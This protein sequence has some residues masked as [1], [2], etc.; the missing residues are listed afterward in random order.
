MKNRYLISTLALASLTSFAH[1]ADRL[2]INVVTSSE[3]SFGVN[4][5][6]VSGEK[7][8]MVIGSGFTRADAL[9]IAA[10]V[11]DTGKDLRTILISDPDPDYYF[12]AEVLKSIFPKADVVATKEVADEIRGHLDNKLKVWR[13]K[14]GANAPR[15]PVIPR[16]L[17]TNLLTVDG[18]AVEVRGTSGLLANRPYV[19]IPSVRTI[20]GNVALWSNLH[21]WTA[22]TQTAAQRNAW[23]DQL[24]EIEALK[25]AVVVPGHMKAGDPLDLNSV[26]FTR[27]YLKDFVAAV[28]SAKDSGALFDALQKQYPDA[29]LPIALTIGSKVAKK[30]M[31][32]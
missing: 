30:E 19:W 20:T 10:A 24:D 31:S 16:V 11:V 3:A 12:G 22:D 8:A 32:W 28:P 2:K 26:H 21:V 17:R 1:A 23:L 15:Q 5:T 25:P 4:A 13:P 27:K 14:L 18:E 7:E 6:V 29:G 9:R